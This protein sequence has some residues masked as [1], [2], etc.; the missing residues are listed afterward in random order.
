MLAVGGHTSMGEQETA[1]IH[2]YDRTSA[3]WSVIGEMPMARLDA[4]V[5]V[6]EEGELVVVGGW[7]NSHSDRHTQIGTC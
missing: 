6:F 5:S 7:A 3:A 1:A 2:A 4:C